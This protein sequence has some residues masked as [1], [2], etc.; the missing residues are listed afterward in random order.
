MTSKNR[1]RFKVVITGTLT[2][3]QSI[4]RQVLGEYANVVVLD[5]TR[6]EELTGHIEDAD[7]I[8]VVHDLSLSRK[9]IEKLD[10][11]KAIICCSVGFNNVDITCARK[12]Q[13]PVIN[14]PDYGTEEVANSAIGLM[15][16][17]TRGISF[18]NSFLRGNN[19]PW[20][21]Q[22]GTPR[23]RLRDRVFGIVGLG[24]IGTATALRAQHL[25]MKVAFYDPY[26]KDGFDKALGLT[27]IE[28]LSELLEK[29]FVLSLHCPLTSETTKM[30][31]SSAISNMPKGS[32]LINTA[33]GPIVE[34]NA[35]PNAISSGQL[36]GAGIDVLENEPPDPTDPLI[37]AW[38]DPNHPAHHRTV[39]NSH[40]AF[41]CEEGLLEIQ[42][43][44]IEACRR[45]LF[46]LPLRNIVN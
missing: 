31:N 11:C 24:R 32:Y 18:L 17:L 1:H 37:R 5:G 3:M 43:K 15:L 21:F 9:T 46:G 26:K 20:S 30:I 33:R 23:F 40:T 27:R 36:A 13:I 42:T 7:A 19:G 25:G 8:M 6:E 2:K 41:Y 28:T 39:I 34:T 44:A 10:R 35:I 14:I 29:S 22:H 16:T 38:R 12:R 45:V 4:A